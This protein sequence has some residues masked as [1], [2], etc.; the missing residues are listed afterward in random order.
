MKHV[1]SYIRW[2]VRP[3]ILSFDQA[4]IQLTGGSSAVTWNCSIDFTA[5]GIDS[6]R[7]CWLTFA[8][9]LANGAA[10][11][12]SEWQA[13]FSNWQL[14]QAGGAL[15]APL[16]IAG[17]GSV[18]IEEDSPACTFSANWTLES[19]FYSQYF[20]NAASLL[21]ESVTITYTCQFTH[22]LYIGTSLYGTSA[23]A[24]G[25]VLVNDTLY[26]PMINGQFYS[27]R[28]VAGIRIDGDTETL[29]DCRVNTGS[30]LITRRLLRSSVAPGKHTVTIRVA[31][32]GVVYFD[33]LEAA[34]LSNVPDALTPR[35]NISAALDFDTDQTYK[36]SPAR[37]MWMMDQ[38]GYA[39]PMNEYLGVFWWNQRIAV[40]ASMSTAEV[41]FAGT[42]VPGDS[43]ILE[44]SPT[45]GVFDPVNGVQL[46]KSVFAGDTL[47][48]IA[49]HFAAYINGFSTSSWATTTGAGVLTITGRSPS[50]PYNL[51]LAE[52][53]NFLTGNPLPS[54]RPNLP[55]ADIQPGS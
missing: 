47:A 22:N 13:T 29:L 33:F 45:N 1:S 54:T 6:I 11:A 53:V 14:T 24:T 41:I 50:S 49:A 9:S 20:A 8:P 25:L 52:K 48:T 28:G 18:R 15:S 46:G 39:G 43:I 55:A 12:P 31:E 36:V 35:I 26:N 17:P 5:L 4:Q 21:N 37:L 3:P 10:Y 32:A 40:G 16:Q 51:T 7:Q 34:V 2:P 44:F 19:G 27:D 23:T 38:L 30:A 42:F